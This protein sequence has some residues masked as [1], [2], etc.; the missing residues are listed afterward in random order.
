MKRV[1]I[2]L[3]L[4]AFFQNIFSQNA[5]FMNINGS[6]DL[7]IEGSWKTGFGADVTYGKQSK[8]KPDAFTISLATDR[9]NYK[10]Y[11]YINQVLALRIGYQ[12][13]PAKNFYLHPAVG[14]QRQFLNRSDY[15]ME[16]AWGFGAGYLSPL[17]YGAINS[18]AKIHGGRGNLSWLSIGMGYQFNIGKNQQ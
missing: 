9:F 17:K 8:T 15:S 1:V 3:F 4:L 5:S 18:F 14:I 2:A 7:P 10:N 13:F 12:L 6:I 16:V 11:D